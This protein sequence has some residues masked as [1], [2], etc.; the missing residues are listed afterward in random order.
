VGALVVYSQYVAA[1]KEK[2]ELRNTWRPT[3]P[4]KFV[5]LLPAEGMPQF[6][7]MPA[8]ATLT[9]YKGSATEAKAALLRQV[10]KLVKV[11]P[12]LCG[13][14]QRNGKNKM[15]LW[16]PEVPDFL[17][18]FGEAEDACVLPGASWQDMNSPLN[19]RFSVK[20]GGECLNQDEP[21]FRV[22]VIR[23]T[24]DPNVEQ[25]AVMVSMS[26]LLGD[27]HT[28][29][30]LYGS[31]NSGVQP[32]QLEVHRNFEADKKGVEAVGIKKVFWMMG[33]WQFY[34]GLLNVLFRGVPRYRAYYLNMEWVEAEKR[35][36]TSGFVSS[37][38]VLTS[39]FLGSGN[40]D[41]GAMV[42]NLRNRVVGLGDH[43]A[44]N[45]QIL[46]HYW[47]EE[48]CT[49]QGVRQALLNPPYYKAGREDVPSKWN[50]LQGNWSLV[51]SWVSFYREVRLPGAT[52]I[53][54]TPTAPPKLPVLCRECAFIFKPTPSTTAICLTERNTKN[55]TQHPLLGERIF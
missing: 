44:G 43:Q 18:C 49:A 41:A 51:S 42:M 8:P 45:Y 47:P 37:N 30:T 6:L 10:A 32:T 17:E 39:W 20:R 53:L 26:H 54:H 2:K 4:G 33:K 7:V 25:F 31:L 11:N 36:I 1:K 52:Q 40:Y 21:L 55:R 48:C 28:Y 46:I 24:A 14:L 12:W 29:Y 13:R 34:G 22:V 3:Q 19:P 27:G 15:R 5:E 38:D 50:C 35:K 9:F 23:L 16:V